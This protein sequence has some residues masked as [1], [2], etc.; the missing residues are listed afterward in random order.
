MTG[1]SNIMEKQHILLLQAICQPDS[2]KMVCGYSIQLL[3]DM[4]I[5]GGNR[6]WLECSQPAPYDNNMDLS[7]NIYPLATTTFSIL[8][9]RSNFGRDVYLMT[10]LSSP[11]LSSTHPSSLEAFFMGGESTKSI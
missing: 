9:F 11:L 5:M 2:L 8:S 3:L 10:R 4:I 1:P 7:S 6:F